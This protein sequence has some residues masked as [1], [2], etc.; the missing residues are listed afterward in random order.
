MNYE[1]HACMGYA[2]RIPC[3][4]WKPWKRFV[5][6]KSTSSCHRACQK[7]KRRFLEHEQPT[8][9]D[10]TS[11]GGRCQAAAWDPTGRGGRHPRKGWFQC[12]LA[13]T[14]I[15]CITD[16]KTL[17][18]TSS[19]GRLTLHGDRNQASRIVQVC[20]TQRCLLCFPMSQLV[21]PAFVCCNDAK[22]T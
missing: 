16:W 11:L 14:E 17:K 22:E 18:D 19:L 8:A 10:N 21:S 20:S 6:W 5:W 13:W 4:K 7:A 1:M 12:G 9:P 2:R 15:L 3:V